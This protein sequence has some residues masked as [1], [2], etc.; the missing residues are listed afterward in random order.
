MGYFEGHYRLFMLLM[1][2]CLKLERVNTLVYHGFLI[3]D[4]YGC[5]GGTSSDG[6]E[7]L[8]AVLQFTTFHLICRGQ[9]LWATTA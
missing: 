5:S 7:T 3:Y 4:L 8:K 1:Y 6:V 9:R 2:Q